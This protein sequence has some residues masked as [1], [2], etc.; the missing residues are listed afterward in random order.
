MSKR[1]V[2]KMGT[3]V[4]TGGAHQLD[5]PRMVELVHNPG[6]EEH[7]LELIIHAHGL[8]LYAFSFTSCVAPGRSTLDPGDDFFMV[9]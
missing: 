3:S 5:H 9:Q 1:I 4:L 2:V 8:A 7:E 6:F